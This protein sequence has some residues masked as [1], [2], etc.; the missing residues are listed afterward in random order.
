MK[1]AALLTDFGTSDH[2]VGSMKAALLAVDPDIKIVDIAHDIKPHDVRAAGYCL[3]ACYRD[4]PKDTVFISVVDPGVGSERRAIAVRT[5]SHVFIAPDNGLLDLVVSSCQRVETFDITDEELFRHPVS[6]TFHGRDI[7]A[8]VGA[9]ILKGL[10]LEKVGPSANYR[11]VALMALAEET[12]H[13]EQSAT[14][15]HIDRFGNLITGFSESDLPDG[16]FELIY[17]GKKI[18][19]FVRHFAESDPGTAFT[20]LGSTGMLEVATF[21]ASAAK[22]LG[23]SA[24]DIV[25]LRATDS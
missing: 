6:N 9:H 7:F 3:F 12:S 25:L 20:Y 1:I 17:G 11:P 4:F 16:P 19:H 14:I 23:A 8:P 5:D 15:L 13:G 18:A 2:Y 22:L 10:P 24:G 21:G